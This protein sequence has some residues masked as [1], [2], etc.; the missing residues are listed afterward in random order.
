MKRDCGQKGS[1]NKAGVIVLGDG[2]RFGQA[3][4]SSYKM[5]AVVN[6]AKL[7]VV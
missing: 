3:R 4:K 1:Y 5:K 2:A 7:S 6:A